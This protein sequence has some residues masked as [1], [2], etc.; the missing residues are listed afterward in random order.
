MIIENV[1]WQLTSV[2]NRNCKYC[3]GPSHIQSLTKSEVFKIIDCLSSYGVKQLGITGGE[4][5]MYPDIEEI[6]NYAVSI[7]LNIYLS[8]NCDYYFTYA[9]LIKEKVSIIGIPIDGSMAAER[10]D[11]PCSLFPTDT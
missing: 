6:I 3:F 2:C 9:K 10:P 11:R 4:P 1:D 8:T 5:L 7:G